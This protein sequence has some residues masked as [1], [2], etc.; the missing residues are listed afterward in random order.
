METEVLE[1]YSI[2]RNI[3]KGGFANV[4]YAIHKPS[5]THVAIKMISK[6]LPNEDDEEHL[7]RIK[8]EISFLKQAKHPFISEL[9]EVIETPNNFYIV[10]EY[11][12]N[13][14]LL[15]NIN[16][17]GVLNETDASIVF[18]QLI[19]VIKYLHEE[20]HIAHRDI[21]AEN[22]LFDSSRNIRVIDFGLSNTPASDNTLKTQCGSPAYAPPEM[23]LGHSY[24]YSSDI[25][26]CGIVLFAIVCG[27]LPFEDNNLTRL[28]QK[29]IFKE[30]EI[31]E[32]ISPQLADLIKK[33][34]TKNP[35]ER[36]TIDDIIR[37]PW[38]HDQYLYVEEKLAK[39]EYDPAYFTGSLSQ[40]GYD[41]L[42]VMKDVE[43]QVSNLGT[44][45]YHIIH[46]EYFVSHFHSLLYREALIPERKESYHM[47]SLVKPL[48]IPESVKASRRKSLH[49][50]IHGPIVSPVRR[51]VPLKLPS[52]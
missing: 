29:I 32:N 50:Q 42:A 46:R 34:L 51:R 48:V 49:T 33:L 19:M 52:I 2:V 30:V 3:G 39:F 10:M 11:V 15:N 26:S 36:I 4:Y 1:N 7:I 9:F 25:W 22:I 35:D 13:G 14:T 18:S 6:H 21:K 17:R 12:R 8:R 44:I 27:Y 41:Y 20:C 43:N 40:L 47:K 23:I 45:S 16:E 37:H 24:T 28:A 38:L 5:S 31:P